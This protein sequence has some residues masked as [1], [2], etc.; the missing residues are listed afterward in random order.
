MFDWLKKKIGEYK[1]EREEK[2]LLKQI[3]ETRKKAYLRIARRKAAHK[4]AEKHALKEAKLEMEKM[5]APKPSIGFTVP[6]IFPD[7]PPIAGKSKR[8]KEVDFSKYL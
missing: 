7:I 2:K 8:K 3:Y 6:E 5:F 4:L 1:Q